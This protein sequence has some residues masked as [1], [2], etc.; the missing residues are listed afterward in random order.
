[1]EEFKK[2]SAGGLRA[3]SGSGHVFQ[4]APISTAPTS[5]S[6]DSGR[7]GLGPSPAP[8]FQTEFM[9]QKGGQT[10]IL[11]ARPW[12]PVFQCSW[13]LCSFPQCLMILVTGGCGLQDAKMGCGM[14]ISLRRG[15]RL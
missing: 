6:M 5:V 2:E 12:E 8:E 9:D 10:L 13:R 3:A 4:F 1:M 15:L 11:L 7:L 14:K